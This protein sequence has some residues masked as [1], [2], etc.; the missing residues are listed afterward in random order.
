VGF[1]SERGIEN[2]AGH[3]R[4]ITLRH[5]NSMRNEQFCRT[6]ALQNGQCGEQ[7]HFPKLLGSDGGSTFRDAW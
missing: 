1:G 4:H 3:R 5:I 7:L 2:G 6:S